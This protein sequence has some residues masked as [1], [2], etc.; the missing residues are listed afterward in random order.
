MA[1]LV[2][3]TPRPTEPHF[4]LPE[5]PRGGQDP[6]PGQ[7]LRLLPRHGATSKTQH[8]NQS[9]GIFPVLSHSPQREGGSQG[10]SHLCLSC[11]G[12]SLCCP[13]LLP[14][15]ARHGGA[16]IPATPMEMGHLPAAALWKEPQCETPLPGSSLATSPRVTLALPQG[17]EL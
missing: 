16:C 2:T 3:R 10:S 4:H 12:C 5:P 9:A 13:V 11:G 6:G 14:Q 15:R 17:E 1:E 8:G 7:D